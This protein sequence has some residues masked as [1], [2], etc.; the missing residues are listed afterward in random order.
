MKVLFVSS[1]NNKYNDIIPFIK[2]QG[3]SLRDLNIDVQFYPIFGKGILGYFYA[4]RNLK[5]FLKSNR[6]DLIHAH[7]IL[8]AWVARLASPKSKLVISLMG[9]DAYGRIVG[10][11]KVKFSSRYLTLLTFFIQPFVDAIICKSPNILNY[12]YLKKKA[13]LLPNGV[14]LNKFYPLNLDS[15]KHLNLESD[16]FYVLFLGNKSDRR[17]NFPLIEASFKVL[18]NKF[19]RPIELL[20]PFPVSPV[21]VP[22]WLNSVNI[23]ALTSFEEG[24]PNLIK[25]AMAMNVPIVSTDV[26]DVSFLFEGCEGCIVSSFDIEEF[27]DKMLYILENQI[28]SQGRKKI[29]DLELSVE[30]VA[31]RLH[32]IY[33]SI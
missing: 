11:N 1:G 27:S 7:F 24:S 32:T 31:K 2:N 30:D 3:N 22:L 5:K 26:G 25:E 14:D 9:T 6:F 20:S 19:D 16:K 21:E 18:Q 23:L 28:V 12:V 29:L 15:R 17:K 10:I 13:F 8:S 33:K 4:Y